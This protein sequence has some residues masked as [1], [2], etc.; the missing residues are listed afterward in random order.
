MA[1]SKASGGKPAEAEPRVFVKKLRDGTE[2]V[3]HVTAAPS[4]EVEA[5]FE[6]YTEQKSSSSKSSG[7]SSAS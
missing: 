2:R 1:D 7:K 4:S 6:G 3:R 5:V